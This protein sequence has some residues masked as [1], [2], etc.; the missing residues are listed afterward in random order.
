MRAVGVGD[1][2]LREVNGRGRQGTDTVR[3][4]LVKE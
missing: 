2:G 3:K 4:R 1:A